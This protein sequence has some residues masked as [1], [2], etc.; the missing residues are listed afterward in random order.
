MRAL[1]RRR[2]PP[3]CSRSPR[4]PGSATRSRSRCPGSG[5]CR[6]Q[7]TL[8][9]RRRTANGSAQPRRSS[10]SAVSTSPR[11]VFTSCGTHV[12]PYVPAA[13]FGWPPDELLD[14]RELERFEDN[15]GTDGRPDAAVPVP[16]LDVRARRLAAHC[17]PRADGG[18]LPPGGA[19]PAAGGR[20]HVGPAGVRQPRRRCGAA[21]GGA[22]AAARPHRRRAASISRHCACGA[23]SRRSASTT[24][25]R[26]SRTRS[27]ATTAR[28]PTP[29]SPA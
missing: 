2:E 8:G 17:A 20:R 22:R 13:V 5:S 19:R 26:P 6:R 7:S 14:V 18:R 21:A 4:H 11:I 10:A 15:A 23:S 24:G 29:G 1:R 27:S 25:R 9:P 3:Y 28:S 16:R 12:K